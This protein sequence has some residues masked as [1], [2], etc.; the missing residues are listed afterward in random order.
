V[1]N[2]RPLQKHD[3]QIDTILARDL[4]EYAL[5]VAAGKEAGVIPIDRSRAQK[6]VKN[7]FAMPDSPLLLISRDSLG[8][9]TGYLGLMPGTVLLQGEIHDIAWTTTGYV[10]RSSNTIGASDALCGRARELYST[11]VAAGNSVA[12]V[13]FFRRIGWQEVISNDIYE[14]GSRRLRLVSMVSQ[15]AA[16][17]LPRIGELQF[18]PSPESKAFARRDFTRNHHYYFPSSQT[19]IE[20]MLS[21]PW[22]P[23]NPE[24]TQAEKKY[25]F[26]DTWDSIS[27]HVYEG[28]DAGMIVSIAKK[29]EIRMKVLDFFSRNDRARSQLLRTAICVGKEIEADDLL[30]PKN[31]L[32]DQ[33]I[34][35]A[36]SKIFKPFPQSYFFASNDQLFIDSIK[37]LRYSTVDGDTRFW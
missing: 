4:V 14:A 16:P 29:S 5:S 6:W 28:S 34:M 22:F 11:I 24:P 32:V 31:L 15:L 36:A 2:S 12:A 35:G 25:L 10:K 21:D 3:I 33:G 7:P 26:G 27:Y 17:L 1:G 23:R 18:Y 9:C 19:V 8:K 20:W 30:V 13:R 37:N